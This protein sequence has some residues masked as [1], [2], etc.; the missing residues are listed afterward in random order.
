MEKSY[1]AV[2]MECV[3]E[4]CGLMP[5]VKRIIEEESER[6]EFCAC[7]GKY[8]EDCL[9]AYCEKSRWHIEENRIWFAPD[10]VVPK[11][12]WVIDRNTTE[13]ELDFWFTQDTWELM[14]YVG[15]FS[16][17]FLIWYCAECGY[18]FPDMDEIVESCPIEFN[19][20]DTVQSILE[21]CKLYLG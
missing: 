13:D 4:T 18:S 14:E 1:S 17:V 2:Y 19:E 10:G 6:G 5:I 15:D 16:E 11:K 7:V 9:L 3:A 21:K 8:V 20:E 12:Q